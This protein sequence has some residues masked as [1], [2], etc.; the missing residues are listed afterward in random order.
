MNRAWLAFVAGATLFGCSS[1]PNPGFG[2]PT[3]DDGGQAA[4]SSSGGTTASSGGGALSSSGAGG[5]SS[6]MATSGSSSG[7]G[8]TGGG[9]SGSGSSGGGVGDAG[10]P[11]INWGT[12]VPAAGRGAVGDHSRSR[13]SR[14]APGAEVYMCQVFANPFGGVDTDISLDAR[15]D[16]HRL[17]PLLFSSASRPSTP[18]VEPAMGTLGACAGAGLEFHPFPFLSQQPNWTV[19][20]PSDSNG[21]PMGYPLV[22]SEP[23]D[24]ERALPEHRLR[25]DHGECEHRHHPGEGGR[26]PDARRQPLSQPGEHERARERDGPESL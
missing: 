2:D 23:A 3:G 16:E 12:T 18:L 4:S 15:D 21:K 9:S 20:Y 5:S 17:A 6:G 11:G 14:L 24:D 25:A 7:A 10:G 8:S 1:T 26:G 13:R 22:G 19:N